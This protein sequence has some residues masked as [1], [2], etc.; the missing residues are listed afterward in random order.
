MTT[1]HDEK[2]ACCSGAGEYGE[3]TVVVAV[4]PGIPPTD[5][6]TGGARD[7]FAGEGVMAVPG[8]VLREMTA[9][10]LPADLRDAYGFGWS[11][12]R[13]KIADR[14]AASSRVMLHRI[15]MAIRGT[16]GFLRPNRA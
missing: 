11:P 3:T 7:L 9:S 4:S 1:S 15:P 14:A 5:A 6:Q 13:Q 12:G 2:A 10:L 16:P 8:W